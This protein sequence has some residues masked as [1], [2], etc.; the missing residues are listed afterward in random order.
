MHGTVEHQITHHFAEA[1][2]ITLA[3]LMKER[4]KVFTGFEVEIFI[5]AFVTAFTIALD[6]EVGTKEMKML[7]AEIDKFMKGKLMTLLGVDT[8]EA[9]MR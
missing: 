4:R 2:E 3:K 1:I 7:D 5:S 9:I 6:I 8:Y